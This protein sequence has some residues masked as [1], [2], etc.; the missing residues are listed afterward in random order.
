MLRSEA[1]AI[2]E[3]TTRVE[4]YIGHVELMFLKAIYENG[5]HIRRA[6]ESEYA[7]LRERHGLAQEDAQWT[8]M[9][10]PDSDSFVI[11]GQP[12]WREAEFALMDRES[13]FDFSKSW[14]PDYP[15]ESGLVD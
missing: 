13:L 10:D 4:V 1:T 7:V 2:D 15:A 12:A 9:L 8:W 11:A 5:L 3:T 14:P 6:S